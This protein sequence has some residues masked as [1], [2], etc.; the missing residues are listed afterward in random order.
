MTSIFEKYVPCLS[1]RK[2]EKICPSLQK[3]M[4]FSFEVFL[5]KTIELE[6]IEIVLVGDARAI[7]FALA[8]KT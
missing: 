5:I 8:A 6:H 1:Y 4:E 2:T 3:N 7:P